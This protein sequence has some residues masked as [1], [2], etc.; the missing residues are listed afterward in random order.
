MNTPPLNSTAVGWMKAGV[1][2]KLAGKAFQLGD[3]A[4]LAAQEGRQVARDRRVLRVGQAELRQAGAR[5]AER[6]APR[7]PPAGRSLRAMVARDLVA[8]QLGADRAA[9]QLGA[10]ARAR[11]PARRRGARTSRRAGAPWRR[12]RRGS[13]RAS[14]RRR[15]SCPAAAS[16]RA[17]TCG[18]RQVHVVA[19]EQD[20]VADG[21]AV[22]L[23][24]ALALAHGDQR[25]VAGAAADVD[26]QDDVARLHLLAPARRRWPGSSCRAPP[27]ALRAASACRSRRRGRPRP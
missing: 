23:Q 15:A 5:A 9:D 1:R 11:R 12:G 19:A 24:V 27:A 4:A 8:R 13:A 21:D 25:E 26:D 16:L 20:V 22:Q 18:Q 6:A 7:R 17:T 3:G 2:V 14:A 10:A